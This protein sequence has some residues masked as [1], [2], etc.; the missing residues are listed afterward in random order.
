ME[1]KTIKIKWAENELKQN[2]HVVEFEDGCIVIDAGC[3]PEDVKQLTNKPIKA[4]LLT[5]AHFDHIKHVQEYDNLRIKVYA[6]KAILEMLKNETNNASIY[7]D[8]PTKYKINNL[9]LLVDQDDLEIGELNIKCLYTPGHTID[10]MCYLINNEY[11]FTGD[12]VFSVAVG[13][14]D[15]PTGNTNELIKSL[16]RILNLDYKMLLTGHGRPSDKQEQKTNIP[17]WIEYLNKGEQN[18]CLK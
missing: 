4:V 5:H 17:K 11:L 15:L 16:N 14:T 6:H 3:R 7:F 8:E 1:V 9:F 12:T 13:R 2:T 10:S 18:I